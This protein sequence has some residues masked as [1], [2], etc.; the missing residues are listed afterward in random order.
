MIRYFK[1][2]QNYVEALKVCKTEAEGKSYPCLPN[3]S[4]KWLEI[5]Q[6]EFT[7]LQR[8]LMK[9]EFVFCER[10]GAKLTTIKGGTYNVI[11]LEYDQRT[12]TYTNKE[13]PAEFSQGGFP[14]GKDCAKIVLA[15]H[16]AAEHRVHLTRVGGGHNRTGYDHPRR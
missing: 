15:E 9:N 14:F 7:E 5:E 2:N 1:S 11:R 10:C 16:E 4:W 8:S 13:V 6:D 3:E 12:G